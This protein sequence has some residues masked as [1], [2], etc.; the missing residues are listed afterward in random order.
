MNSFIR[1]EINKRFFQALDMIVQS[2][3][4]RGEATFCNEHNIDRR[5]FQKTRIKPTEQRIR[6]EWIYYLS[7]DFNISADWIFT[8]KGG[9]FRSF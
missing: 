1:S 9:M 7:T 4:I 2:G 3:A 8:G 5:N 6:I